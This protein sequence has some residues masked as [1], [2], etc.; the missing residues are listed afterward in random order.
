LEENFE[1]KWINTKLI[2]SDQSYQRPVDPVRVAQI[3]KNFDRNLVNPPKLSFRDGRY[4]VY[5]GGHTIAALKA[6]N[7]GR[8]LTLMCKVTYGL[9]RQDEAMLFEEQNGLA[10]AIE[11]NYKLRSQ[12]NRG[13][14]S[15][16]SM[17]RI[18][19]SHGFLVDFAKGTMRNRIIA[20]GTLLRVYKRLGAS[21]Y[22]ILLSILR[23]AWDGT[24]D[25]T[26]KEIIEGLAIFLDQ[27]GGQ[28]SRV[29]LVKKLRAV[30][31]IE[32]I[33]EGKLSRASGSKKYAQQIVYI[34]NKKQTVNRLEDVR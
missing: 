34:Y 9:T 23:D 1:F 8:D 18:A 30:S 25:S 22:S 33:R 6:K 24:P 20:V 32:I 16:M 15:V 10:R 2:L 21:G 4:Y 29:T 19:E 12:F 17:V 13:E 27:Y 31:P 28:Y 14:E 7:G 5:D 3:V 26:K 11:V